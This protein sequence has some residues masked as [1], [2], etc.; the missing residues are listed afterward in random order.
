MECNVPAIKGVI[1][2][3]LDVEFVSN[4]VFERKMKGGY[5]ASYVRGSEVVRRL[6]E[7]FGHNWSFS[8][9]KEIRSDAQKQVAILGE[10]TVTTFVEVSEA[11]WQPV[12]IKKQQ[13]GG[14]D[15]KTYKNSSECVDFP[16]D[17]KAA[18]TD[19]LKKCA[20]MF[21]I[22]LHLYDT[23]EPITC[24]YDPS[25]IS[26]PEEEQ[27]KA[28][29]AP[30]TEIQKAAIDRLLEQQNKTEKQLLKSLGLKDVKEITHKLAAELVTKRH[31]FFK[32]PEQDEQL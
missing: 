4:I 3:K 29:N 27:E 5:I 6:N 10:L 15:L 19:A 1:A 7:A 23:D 11:N 12:E 16:N 2:G 31:E 9:V 32:E 21:G 26:S 20:T 14:A 28:D 25:K 13:W 22:G 24:T 17:Y 8:V 18:T 30:L